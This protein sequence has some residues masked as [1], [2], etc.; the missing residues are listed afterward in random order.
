MA[1]SKLGKSDPRP[2]A[3]RVR[4]TRVDLEK[5]FL[6]TIIARRIAGVR[7][8]KAQAVFLISR[9]KV[10]CEGIAIVVIAVGVMIVIITPLDRRTRFLLDSFHQLGQLAVLSPIDRLQS[11]LIFEDGSTIADREHTS[12]QADPSVE[13]VSQRQ[14]SLIKRYG[15]EVAALR[16]EAPLT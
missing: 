6:G 9:A 12:R 2:R 16:L 7:M 10:A 1:I 5:K 8:A 14:N 3:D 11:F 15:V 13:I 4:Q